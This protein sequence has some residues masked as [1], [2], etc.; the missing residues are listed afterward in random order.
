[1]AALYQLCAYGELDE[2]RAELARGGD[3]NYKDS[4]ALVDGMTALMRAVFAEHN[5]IVQL[6]LEQPAV[7]TN[8]KS[9]SGWTAL[10]CAAVFNNPE[11]ARMLL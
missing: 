8:E 6:L 3:V 4:D 1:M 11:G 5:S 7:K 9:N 2:V 10:H